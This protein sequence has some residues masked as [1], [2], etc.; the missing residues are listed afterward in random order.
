[1]IFDFI[2][3]PRSGSLACARLRCPMC[4][5]TWEL[6]SASPMP[7]GQY[8]SACGNCGREGTFTTP[9]LAEMGIE[10]PAG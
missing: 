1:M 2:P 10:A 6:K 4:A 9:T 5:S 3:L 7:Q 8:R